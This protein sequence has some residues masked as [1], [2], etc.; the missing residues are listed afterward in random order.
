MSGLNRYLYL[1]EYESWTKETGSEWNIL[2][3]AVAGPLTG[4]QLP[5]VLHGNHFWFAW[6]AFMPDTEVR[7]DQDG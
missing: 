2:G 5:P 7:T 3:Q 4:A 1:V 6:A